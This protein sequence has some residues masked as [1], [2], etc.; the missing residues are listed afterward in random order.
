MALPIERF[1]D[2]YSNWRYN[3]FSGADM[4][5]EAEEDGLIIPGSSPFIIQLLELPHHWD[6]TQVSVRCYGVKTDVDQNSG[7]G[8][9]ILYVASTV[10]F[11]PGNTI[12]IDRGGDREE[13]KIIDTIQ[14]G[15]SLT[16]TVNLEFTHTAVQEDDVEKYIA[17]TETRGA[18]AQSQ[19]RVDYPPD[20]GEGTGLIEFNNADADKEVRVNY[21]ATGSPALEEFLNTKIS[22]PAGNPDDN[23]IVGFV[24]GAPD[25]RNNPVCYF[26][27]GPVI[28][29]ASGEDESCLLFRFKRSAKQS[30]VFLELKGAKLHQG[31]YTELK[32]HNHGVGTLNISTAPNHAHAKGT[33]AGT[34]PTHTHGV[35][36]T[37]GTE[38]QSHKHTP[39][40][41][42]GTQPTH[43]HT[44]GTLAGTQPTHTHDMQNH[45]HNEVETGLST[46]G[47][48]AAYEIE[49]EVSAGGNDAVTIAGS[50][51]AGGNQAVTIAGLSSIA[52]RSHSHSI[53]LT[54]AAG[55]NQAVTIAGSTASTGGHSHTIS[56]STANTGDSP[57]TY[58]HALK[59]YVNGVNKT[60]DILTK[61]GLGVLGDGT[62]GHDFV[63][64]G[65]GEMDIS[66]LIVAAQ[67]HEL[68]VTEPTADKG[69][70]VLCHIE[71]Y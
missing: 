6:P 35:S 22:Y 42:A 47:E 60:A 24:S 18:P 55:G 34:Q 65:T 27:E 5:V 48:V 52:D 66:D 33:L 63:T 30:K 8:T 3:P 16:V 54:S 44:K 1:K 37:S 31:Y 2:K 10:D 21:P 39:G 17:F 71:V 49:K 29:H 19:Y 13:E 15:I 45:R 69:G 23:Q 40:T 36:G 62:S 53:S 41:L 11:S 28:Y 25:W 32:E 51:A 20:D 7:I 64:T 67:I 58:P 70:R 9:L 68:K 14:G 56:G 59:V 46:T 4:T 50:T 12:I 57:K 43:T 26:H 61:S 38:S